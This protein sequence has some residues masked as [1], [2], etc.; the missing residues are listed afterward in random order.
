MDA[1]V[2]Q[3]MEECTKGS[4]DERLTFPSVVA[5]LMALSAGRAP[6]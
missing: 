6:L 5:M 1:H 4:D 3:V 2:K